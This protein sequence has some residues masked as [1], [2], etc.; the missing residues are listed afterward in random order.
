MERD[1]V[2]AESQTSSSSSK[3]SRIVYSENR[4]AVPLIYSQFHIRKRQRIAD[5]TKLETA[6]AKPPASRS[7]S[8]R[9]VRDSASASASGSASGSSSAAVA[10]PSSPTPLTDVGSLFSRSKARAGTSNGIVSSQVAFD[11]GSDT[12]R[13]RVSARKLRQM[14]EDRLRSIQLQVWDDRTGTTT[15]TSTSTTP[16]T[17]TAAAPTA[18]LF[19]RRELIEASEEDDECD[20]D[21]LPAA[22]EGFGESRRLVDNPVVSHPRRKYAHPL[23]RNQEEVVL[24]TY[25]EVHGSLMEEARATLNLPSD[26]MNRAAWRHM[27]AMEHTVLNMTVKEKR[28]MYLLMRHLTGGIQNPDV[29]E[30]RACEAMTKSD[31]LLT[32]TGMTLG[33]LSVFHILLTRTQFNKTKHL[34]ELVKECEVFIPEMQQAPISIDTTTSTSR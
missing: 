6:T 15:N 14:A 17:V 9:V 32:E 13:P 28:K 3:G 4:D 1:V 19:N 18:S 26:T 11:F 23:D 7:G 22:A 12:K 33:Q 24:W 16:V 10:I 29:S 31:H 25:D 27:M 5:E 30:Q 34:D 20:D 2:G 8:S 21:D